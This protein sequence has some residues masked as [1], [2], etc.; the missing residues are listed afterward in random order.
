M[1]AYGRPPIAYLCTALIYYRN[2]F[3]VVSRELDTPLCFGTGNKS[4]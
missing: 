4:V 1:F 3:S 2:C